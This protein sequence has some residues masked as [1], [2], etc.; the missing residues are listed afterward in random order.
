MKKK[1]YK[2]KIFFIIFTLILLINYFFQIYRKPTELLSFLSSP[3]TPYETWKSY[4]TLF[5]KHSLGAITPDFLAA[6]A[7]VESSGNH[8]GSPSWRIRWTG[9]IADFYS[10]SSSSFGLFQTTVGTFNQSKKLCLKNGVILKQESYENL[11][12]QNF[13]YNRLIPSSIIQL[14]AIQL[15]YDIQKL[16]SIK[17]KAHSDLFKKQKTAALIHLCGK[18]QTRNFIMNGLKKNSQCGTHNVQIYLNKIFYYKKIFNQFLKKSDLQLTQ[19]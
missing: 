13:F 3:K 7:Q 16:S 12:P 15:E 11:C 10:P 14:T 17:T 18:E 1:I 8:W 4:S 19:L 2:F 6:L 5:I 9:P